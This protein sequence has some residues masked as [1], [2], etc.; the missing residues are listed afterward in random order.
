MKKE[1]LQKIIAQ[2][3]YCS[4]RSAEELIA[5]GQVTINNKL[6]K[7]GDKAISQDIIKIN[8]EKIKSPE[9][10]FYIALN[11]PQGYTTT[12]EDRFA[13]KKI[14]DLIDIPQR[15]FPVGRLDKDTEG[16]I[17]LT[18][19]GDWANKISHP[20]FE[21]EKEYYVE[22]NKILN[23][24]I[25]DK[26]NKGFILED[27]YIKPRI[28]LISYKSCSIV[29]H[30]G[31]NRIVKRIFRHFECHVTRLVRIRIGKFELDD[32][33]VGEWKYIKPNII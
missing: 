25:L 16:L 21:K 24:E 3:G 2:S 28:K 27:G 6:A 5:K 22:L 10:K 30:E 29:I 1:R 31:K 15:I 17:F 13:K 14:I 23:K 11:K 32:L 26:I 20:S 19:D 33:R 8:G 7:L 9:E 18:N 4:R 12:N